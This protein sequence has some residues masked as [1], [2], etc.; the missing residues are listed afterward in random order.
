VRLTLRNPG[1]DAKVSNLVARHRRMALK[2]INIIWET[3]GQIYRGNKL[4]LFSRT[5]RRF[6]LT[7]IVPLGMC[8]MFRSELIISLGMLMGRAAA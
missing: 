5:Q 4:H 1:T 6:I 3:I 2:L 7:Q 8:C